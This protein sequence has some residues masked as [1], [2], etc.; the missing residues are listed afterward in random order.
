[1]NGSPLPR[2][3]ESREEAKRKIQAQ[4]TKGQQLLDAPGTSIYEDLLNECEGWS[5][6]NETLLV[7][8][9]GGHSENSNYKRFT[10]FRGSTIKDVE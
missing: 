5:R 2:L 1:M 4:I 10:R 9:F 3:T 7:K 8:L 6:C